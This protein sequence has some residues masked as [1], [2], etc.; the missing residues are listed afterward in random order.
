MQDCKPMSTPREQNWFTKVFR[1]DGWYQKIKRGSSYLIYMY[2]K[3]V[4]FCF[5]QTV[6]KYYWNYKGTVENCKTCQDI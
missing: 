4:E 5:K 2:E 6:S 3:G 1:N